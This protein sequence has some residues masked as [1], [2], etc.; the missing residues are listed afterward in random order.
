MMTEREKRIGANEVVFREL[1]EQLSG[2]ADLKQQEFGVVCECGD[3]ACTRSISITFAEYEQLRSEGTH[4]AVLP[5]HD[6]PDV[7]NV[8]EK[9]ESYWVVRK[10]AGGPAELADATDPRDR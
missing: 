1:N 3:P 6:I 10:R 2:L 5:G 9:N 4:F 7:E 8:V